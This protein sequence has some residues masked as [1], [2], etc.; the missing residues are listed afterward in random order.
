LVIFALAA[1]DTAEVEP[2]DGETQIVEGVV[3]VVDDLVVHRPAIGRMRMQHDGDR[4]VAVLLRVVAAFQSSVGAGKDYL[5]HCT[6]LM[7]ERFLDAFA[8][9]N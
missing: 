2:Q 7:R 5:W 9:I 8:R 4:R 1:P 3:Q 6:L